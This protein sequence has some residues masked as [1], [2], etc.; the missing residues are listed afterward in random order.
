MPWKVVEVTD[1]NGWRIG[2]CERCRSEMVQVR[3]EGW[4]WPVKDSRVWKCPGC[5]V[6]VRYVG[7]GHRR[8]G[9]RV[10]G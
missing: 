5:G 2:T 10:K 6:V 8:E 1:S 4:P 9:E 7:S 3:C